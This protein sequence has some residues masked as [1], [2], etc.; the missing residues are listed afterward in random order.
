MAAVAVGENSR[1]VVSD[2]DVCY[3]LCQCSH[4]S[5]GFDHQTRFLYSRK[6]TQKDT[7]VRFYSLRLLCCLAAIVFATVPRWDFR[8]RSGKVS[9]TRAE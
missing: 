6:K 5:Q 8:K 4:P 2:I 7:E 9:G 1:P 3:W